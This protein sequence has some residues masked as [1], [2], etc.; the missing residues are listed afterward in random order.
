MAMDGG[1]VQEGE[2][3]EKKKSK[4]EA[5]VTKDGARGRSHGRQ[6]SEEEGKR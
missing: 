2:E 4:G 1:E 6:G 5:G 3:E